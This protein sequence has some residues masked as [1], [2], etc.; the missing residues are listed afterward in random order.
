MHLGLSLWFRQT[1]FL[2]QF[3]F[4]DSMLCIAHFTVFLNIPFTFPFI[5][6]FRPIPKFFGTQSATKLKLYF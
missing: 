1:F 2:I 5:L 6:L 3:H 4:S